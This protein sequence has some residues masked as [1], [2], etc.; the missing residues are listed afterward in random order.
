MVNVKQKACAEPECRNRPSCNWAGVGVG[1]WCSK[2]KAEGMV[3]VRNKTCEHSGCPKASP[4]ALCC[5]CEHGAD[6]T[7]A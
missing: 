6:K 2:H 1:V 3:D 5:F 7:F 4:S